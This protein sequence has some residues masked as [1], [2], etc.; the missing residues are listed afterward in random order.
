MLVAR[1]RGARRSRPEER[2]GDVAQAARTG[3]LPG[4]SWKEGVEV[5]ISSSSSFMS[6]SMSA[7]SGVERYRSPVSGSMASMTDPSGAFLAVSSAAHIVPPPEMPVRSPSLAASA[8]AVAMAEAA[9]MGTSSSL[10]WSGASSSTLGMKSGVQP[11]I[12]CGLKAGGDP[13][14]APS[15][16]R[17]VGMPLASRPASSGSASMI[18]RSGRSFLSARPAPLKVPPVP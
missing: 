5:A 4:T 1:G 15:A 16:S 6:A 13:A 14:G 9:G 17:S 3:S 10:S 12:G 18:L 11:W 8:L 7:K 2:R